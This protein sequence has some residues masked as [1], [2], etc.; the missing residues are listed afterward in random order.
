MREKNAWHKKIN[1]AFRN[2]HKAFC[3][4]LFFI[5]VFPFFDFLI[6]SSYILFL[7]ISTDVKKKRRIK[8][9]SLYS[10]TCK[11]KWV[12]FR[13]T[14]TFFPHTVPRHCIF[15]WNLKCKATCKRMLFLKQCVF[16]KHTWQEK[17][18]LVRGDRLY[19][20]FISPCLL[21]N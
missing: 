6:C 17:T 10:V 1:N 20:A 18:K 15:L 14:W 4:T 16:M 19:S 5:Q 11:L 8:T 2:Y 12:A 9:A 7:W 3:K 21:D 13:Q